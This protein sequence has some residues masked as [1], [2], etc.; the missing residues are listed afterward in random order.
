MMFFPS[1]FHTNE[2]TDACTDAQFQFGAHSAARAL[3]SG[4]AASVRQYGFTYNGEFHTLDTYGVEDAGQ[5]GVG[6]E[7]DLRYLFR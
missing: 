3:K 4:G 1:Q 6:H 5:W 7:D 2:L